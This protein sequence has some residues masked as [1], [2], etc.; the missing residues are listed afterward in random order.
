MD[1]R[2]KSMA[3]LYIQEI[4]LTESSLQEG[5]KGFT[6]MENCVESLTRRI[7]KKGLI[8]TVNYSSKENNPRTTGIIKSSNK[9]TRR[10]SKETVH[11]LTQIWLR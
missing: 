10:Q 1:D 11:E 5:E 4:T 2:R 8:T 6:I 3:G 9:K 7:L